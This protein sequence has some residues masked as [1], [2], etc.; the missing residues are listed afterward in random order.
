MMK[1]LGRHGWH[2]TAIFT[3]TAMTDFPNKADEIYER[4]VIERQTL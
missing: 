2:L 4:C 1:D 3:L